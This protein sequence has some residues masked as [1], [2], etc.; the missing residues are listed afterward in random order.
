MLD[1]EIVK[2]IDESDLMAH[3]ESPLPPWSARRSDLHLSGAQSGLRR[4]G[5][6]GV[7]TRRGQ[8]GV[9]GIFRGRGMCH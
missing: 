5:P 1:E 3:Y 8:S 7:T 6:A 4:L 2:P 9:D